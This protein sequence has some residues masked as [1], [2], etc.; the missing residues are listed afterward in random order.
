MG[1]GPRGRGLAGG[2][3]SV[4][5]RRGGGAFLPPTGTGRGGGIGLGGGGLRDIRQAYYRKIKGAKAL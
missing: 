5:G 3:P 4:G 1:G 2:T